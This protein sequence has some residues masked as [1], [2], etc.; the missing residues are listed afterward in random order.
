MDLMGD[1]SLET[2]RL[3]DSYLCEPHRVFSLIHWSYGEG[4][5]CWPWEMMKS[6]LRHPLSL[7][8]GHEHLN[9]PAHFTQSTYKF[10]YKL[11]DSFKINRIWNKTCPEKGFKINLIAQFRIWLDQDFPD[12]LFAM[13]FPKRLQFH[14]YIWQISGRHFAILIFGRY[15]LK[16]KKKKKNWTTEEY[17]QMKLIENQRRL[18]S[19]M[20]LEYLL[21]IWGFEAPLEWAGYE[22]IGQKLKRLQSQTSPQILNAEINDPAKQNLS[23]TKTEKEIK[24][25]TERHNSWI[26]G[27]EKERNPLTRI[28][29]LNSFVA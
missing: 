20:I 25:I 14:H 22:A 5:L 19:G 28:Q 8:I 4:W 26:I 7:L 1:N 27:S 18:M 23:R 11:L 2:D 21:W 16:K 10:A 15:E 3:E 9:M 12:L 24:P 29:K 13:S 17:F 6:Y